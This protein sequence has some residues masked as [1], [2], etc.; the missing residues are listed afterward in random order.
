MVYDYYNVPFAF[1]SPLYLQMNEYYLIVLQV[2]G[3]DLGANQTLI[4]SK[5]R[6]LSVKWHPDREK[7]VNRK[8][9]AQEKFYEI[10]Q[11]CELLSTSKAKRRRQ[12]KKSHG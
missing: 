5:C 12:N 4:N 10:Q 11:A 1:F 6:Q 3:L 9:D 2:L 8:Q 7:D